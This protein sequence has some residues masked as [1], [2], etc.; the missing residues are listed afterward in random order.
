M[1]N[2]N[3]RSSDCQSF[4]ESVSAYL[5]GELDL[6]E[7]E[8]IEYHIANCEKCRALYESFSA[9]SSD[10][11]SIEPEIPEE[12][13]LRIMDAVKKADSKSSGKVAGLQK[14][15]RK[16]GLWIGAGVAAVFCIALLGSPIFRGGFDVKMAEGVNDAAIC[17][18]D[19]SGSLERDYYASYDAKNYSMEID[20]VELENS[21]SYYL[22][23]KVLC[24]EEATIDDGGSD[25]IEEELQQ[26]CSEPMDSVNTNDCFAVTEKSVFLSM[27]FPER[28][29]LSRIK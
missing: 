3:M 14:K 27:F 18:G 10:I 7:R 25:E 21:L 12:L 24:D 20:D 13:H 8:K 17:K 5:D 6:A 4:L 16:W 15:L 28:G 9:I 11:R 1:E 2:T 29:K 23:T 26:I 22:T 19:L